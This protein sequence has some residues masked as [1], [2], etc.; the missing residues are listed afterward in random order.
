MDGYLLRPMTLV[1]K[2]SFIGEKGANR[3]KLLYVVDIL[4]PLVNNDPRNKFFGF[5]L[6]NVNLSREQ[7]AE[8]KPE[9]IG[10]V[11]K[12]TYEADDYGNAVVSGFRLE[13]YLLSANEEEGGLLLKPMTLMSRRGFI[14]S[15]GANKDVP[16]YVIDVLEPLQESDS[17]GY[18]FRNM[19]VNREQW[20]EIKPEDIGKSLRFVY[21]GY[22]MSGK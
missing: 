19:Y 20:S 2:R 9:D 8:I 1:N 13:E 21:D 10:K 7:W 17:F 11:I 4:K 15:V 18:S 22:L 3:G 14:G 5:E 6:K 16:F 12:F